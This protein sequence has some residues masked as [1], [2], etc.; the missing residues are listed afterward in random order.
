MSETTDT[1]RGRSDEADVDLLIVGA[2]VAG[3]TAAIR[4]ADLGLRVEVVEASPLIGGVAAVSGGF[5]WIG[6][7][8]LAAEAGVADDWREVDTY[9]D[10]LAGSLDVDRDLR[11]VVTR[12]GARMLR[13]LREHAGIEMHLTGR[14][15]MHHPQTAGSVAVGR[16]V[17][18]VEQGARLDPLTRSRL[19]PSYHF[20]DGLMQNEIYGAGG[21]AVA[22]RDLADL[23]RR[24]HEEDVLTMGPG[25]IGA[26]ARAAFTDREVPCRTGTALVDLRTRPD[27]SVE[28]ELEVEGTGTAR[29]TARGV[30]L[31]IGSYGHHEDAAAI[32]GLPA[33]TEQSPR[34]LRGDLFRLSERIGAGLVRRGRIYLSLGFRNEEPQSQDE[35]EVIQVYDALGLPHTVLVN[36][37]GQRF[38]DENSYPA[39]MAGTLQFDPTLNTHRNI[40]AYFIADR[41]FRDNGGFPSLEEWPVKSM[42]E[43][44]SLEELAGLLGIDPDGLVAEVEAFN[45]ACAAG[46]QPAFGR[47]ATS[48]GRLNNSDRNLGGDDRGFLAA[49]SEPP[50][51]GVEVLP[52]AA[53]IYP[54]GF[55]IDPASATVLRQ[56]G[57]PVP[58]VYA[59]GNLVAYGDLPGAYEGGY[60]NARGMAMALLAA[61]DVARRLGR[62]PDGGDAA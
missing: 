61:E 11:D 29:R 36:R 50:F 48:F 16:S 20:R 30:L 44:G 25:L 21:K 6:N 58:G 59:A 54:L 34:I 32:E 13:Y 1:G 35:P 56:D 37:A 26:L 62:G 5:V 45:R 42:V 41:R 28:A 47:G 38:A 3:M 43:A 24:R 18:F 22:Y 33:L 15:D 49:V 39:V 7:N 14:Q 31:A 17:E 9:L 4:A 8:D 12:T 53:G 40:P 57:A 10:G 52:A 19:R 51:Y 60:A 23:L 46:E 55:R 2:G 27:G